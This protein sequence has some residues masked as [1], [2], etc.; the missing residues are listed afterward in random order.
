[1][2]TTLRKL[3]HTIRRVIAETSIHPSEW[4]EFIERANIGGPYHFE[5]CK[6]FLNNGGNLPLEDIDVEM[7]MEETHTD[8]YFGN[9]ETSRPE[10]YRRLERLYNEIIEGVLSGNP[11]E[12]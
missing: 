10:M 5:W 8:Y 4:D 1:M 6:N 7:M 12:Y 2:K 11:V 9:T 3:R